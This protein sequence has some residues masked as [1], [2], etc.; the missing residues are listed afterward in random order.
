MR[1]LHSVTATATGTAAAAS[2]VK[3]KVKPE[4]LRN[5]RAPTSASVGTARHDTLTPA[6]RFAMLIYM[7]RECIK[8][9]FALSTGHTKPGMKEQT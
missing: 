6:G 2:A 9:S 1:E 4:E 7:L 3:S 8:S 5:E